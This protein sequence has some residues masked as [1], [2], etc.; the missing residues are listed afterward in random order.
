MTRIRDSL[1][2]FIY[3]RTVQLSRSSLE[4]LGEP[5]VGSFLGRTHQGSFFFYVDTRLYGKESRGFV[6]RS[7][8]ARPFFRFLV[9]ELL[10]VYHFFF[11]F[12]F[13]PFYF[14]AFYFTFFAR[15][16]LAR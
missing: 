4:K 10:P 1:E 16:C 15:P 7:A 11:L 14:I 3:V 9:R 8:K 5:I 6:Q 13:S 2:D 12:F